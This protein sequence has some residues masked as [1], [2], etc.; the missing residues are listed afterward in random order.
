MY[1][2]TLKRRQRVAGGPYAHFTG[3]GGGGVGAAPGVVPGFPVQGP[4]FAGMMPPPEQQPAAP[5]AGGWYR[6][7]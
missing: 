5:G 4:G 3:D 6:V 2:R 1:L 7:S